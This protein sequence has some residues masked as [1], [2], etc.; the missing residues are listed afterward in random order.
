[1][2]SLCAL[3]AAA[4]FFMAL[5]FAVFQVKR[6][7]RF[8]PVAYILVAVLL[9]LPLDHWLLIEFVRGNLSDLS[10]ATAT[11]CALYL[12]NV[13]RPNSA[14]IQLSL[15]WFVLIIAV[16]LYPMSMGWSYFDPFSM[17]YSS[18]GLYVYLLISL[19]VAGLVAWFIGFQHVAIVITL[20]VL[21]NGLQIYE[22]QNLWVYLIDPIAVIICSVSLLIKGGSNLVNRFKMTGVKNA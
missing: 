7:G 8:W 17:G 4:L 14:N 21:A 3:F 6:W 9:V 19:A 13:V 22:S 2:T 18:N 5:F 10:M 11:I 16:L 15:K 1:M 12:W 20:A